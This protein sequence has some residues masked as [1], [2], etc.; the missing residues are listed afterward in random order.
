MES[1]KQIMIPDLSYEIA[2][3]VMVHLLLLKT[4]KFFIPRLLKSFQIKTQYWIQTLHHHKCMQCVTDSIALP[5]NVIIRNTNKLANPFASAFIVLIFSASISDWYCSS[6]SNWNFICLFCFY[7][8]FKNVILMEQPSAAPT[9][10]SRK[11]L[12][13]CSKFGA[14]NNDLVMK[15]R[16]EKNIWK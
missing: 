10:S 14:L 16:A 11:I 2:V 12:W 1:C 9:P 5:V 8:Y 6:R 13:A 4:I 7:T 15:C 3:V